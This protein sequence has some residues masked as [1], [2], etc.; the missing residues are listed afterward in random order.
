M[1]HFNHCN[2]LS[3]RLLVLI[4]LLCTVHE[5]FNETIRLKLMT[6]ERW[7]WIINGNCHFRKQ[8]VTLQKVN[9]FCHGWWKVEI[10]GTIGGSLL[11]TCTERFHFN[12]DWRRKSDRYLKR[13]AK[14][15]SQ[16]SCTRQCSQSFWS[17]KTSFSSHLWTI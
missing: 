17:V 15:S 5:V 12:N 9:L 7:P 6:F 4:S 1:E 13:N 3:H 11:T 14:L 2:V 8:H 10:F 16:S